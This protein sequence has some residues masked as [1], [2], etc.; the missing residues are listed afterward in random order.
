MV[1]DIAEYQQ[2][3]SSRYTITINPSVGASPPRPRKDTPP[4][5]KG[6]P[7]AVSR[8]FMKISDWKKT[9]LKTKNYKKPAANNP[10]DGTTNGLGW[11]SYAGGLGGGT[12]PVLMHLIICL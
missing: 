2:H 12:P 7:A 8:S 5:P 3:D 4:P 6:A 9:S 11:L 10:D 1:A